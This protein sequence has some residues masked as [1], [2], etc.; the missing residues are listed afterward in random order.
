M[1][2]TCACDEIRTMAGK[3]GQG[4]TQEARQLGAQQVLSKQ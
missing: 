4:E 3:T 1:M 2:A